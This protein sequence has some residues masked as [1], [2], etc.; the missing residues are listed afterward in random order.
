M[1]IPFEELAD[2]ARV[3]VYASQRRLE[4]EEGRRAMALITSFLGDWHVHGK[5]L[6]AAAC[7][8]FYDH[9]LVIGAD[10]TGMAV[11]GCAIDASVRAIKHVESEMG[12]ILS[13]RSLVAFRNGD[14]IRFVTFQSL[15]KGLE[16]GQWSA[17]SL[18]FN[19]TVE[20]M[21]D[22]RSRWLIPVGQSWLS[23]H[24]P[25]GVTSRRV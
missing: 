9:F 14:D 23:R 20:T 5:P 4:P 25:Q 11:S 24:L 7:K 22:L 13:D 16:E 19:P 8:V 6:P 21:A 12:L 3:W 18:V 17:A 15:K 2:H 1:V 10:E